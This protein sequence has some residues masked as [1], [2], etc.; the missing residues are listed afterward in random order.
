MKTAVC[1]FCVLSASA[2]FAQNVGAV[3]GA[4]SNEPVRIVVPDHP[5]HAS[6][7]PMLTEQSL[8]NTSTFTSAQGERPLWEVAPKKVEVPLGDVAR[9]LRQE[10]NVVKKSATVVEN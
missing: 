8:L 10:H 2:A 7:Q 9:T 5:G 4:L 1:L 6:Q 3:T